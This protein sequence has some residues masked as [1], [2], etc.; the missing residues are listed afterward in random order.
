M[1]ANLDIRLRRGRDGTVAALGSMAR[2][3]WWCRWDGDT[4]WLVGSA[5]TPLGEDDVGLSV[6]VGEGVDAKVRS[7]AATIVYA[8]AGAGTH[9]RLSLRV[10]PG[11]SLHWCTEPVIVTE[12][13]R[14]RATT[15]ADV[16]LDG[17]MT[18]EETV[19]FGR[20]REPAGT[21]ASTTELRTDGELV[22]LTS[23]DS[24]L[25]GWNGP[26][27]TAAARSMRTTVFAGTA[28]VDAAV[29]A[30]SATT[31]VLR[32]ERGGLVVTSLTP[33][34]ALPD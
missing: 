15:C 18:L 33:D 2:P 4:L 20:H 23:W 1:R 32:P 7:V 26:G 22:S 28:V 9:S 25:P 12:R 10:A 21:M 8:A 3:P 5:A 19:V 17:A 13:A 6:D 27:G 29:P 14:H 31:A 30:P 34:L 11:A 24:G 16:A